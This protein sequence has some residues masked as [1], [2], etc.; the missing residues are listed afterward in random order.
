MLLAAA[1]FTAPALA[2]V[3]GDIFPAR[4]SLEQTGGG[5]VGATTY[6]SSTKLLASWLPSR[7]PL[8]KFQLWLTD[9]STGGRTDFLLPGTAVQFLLE[10][11]KS[12]TL[13]TVDLLPILLTGRKLGVL[14]ASATT[15][16]ETWHLKGTGNDYQTCDHIIDDS[17]VLAWP[18]R[19]GPGAPA[20]LLGKVRLYH[21]PS[22]ALDPRPS[23]AIGI[24]PG[25]ATSD[26]DSVSSFTAISGFGLR[27]PLTAAYLVD[28]VAAFQAVPMTPSMGGGVRL[29]FEARG[30]DGRTRNMY[31]DNH[32][33]SLGQDFHPGAP[34]IVEDTADYDTGGPAEPTLVIGVEGNPHDPTS[35]MIEARQ[36]KLG[37]PT[38]DSWRWDGAVGSFLVLT[39]QD[40]CGQTNDGIFHASWNGTAFDVTKD[41]SGCA[42]PIALNGHGPVV[43]HL[44]QARYKVYWEDS[45]NGNSDKPLHLLYADGA[46]TGDPSVVDID[47]FDAQ[48]LAREVDFLW[49]DGSLMQVWDESGLGDHVILCPDG[50]LDVQVMYVNLGGKDNSKAPSASTGVGMAVL[51]NP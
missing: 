19:Y 45:T 32:D 17:N 47:D 49:P 44:G 23:V 42:R 35:G 36:S 28:R 39:G 22:F 31:L 13:Y 11:L 18:F 34:T 41:A 14:S 16:R 46:I 25:V 15:P 30:S 1:L 24:T 2:Q 10:D 33:Y 29:F 7:V 37:W 43:H 51:V 26:P 38:L 5:S 4:I 9:E 6:A 12:D 8:A 48:Q 20:N 50:T 21:K 27:Q 3:S 40:V